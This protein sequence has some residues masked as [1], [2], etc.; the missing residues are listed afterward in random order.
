VK[1]VVLAAGFGTRLG[2]LTESSPK[3]ALRI[4]GQPIIAHILGNLARC[5]FE[6]VAVNVHYRSAEVRD[7]LESAP[8]LGLAVTWFPES[9]LLGTAGALLPMREFLADVDGFLVHYGDVLTDH[10]VGGMLG[11]HLV[12][13]PLVSMLVHER[14]ESNSIVVVD[15]DDDRVVRFLER[16]SPAEREGLDSRWVNS[17]IYAC[18]REVLELVPPPPSD[19]ARDLVPRAL[20]GGTVLVEEL[21]GYRCAVDSPARIAEA[22]LALADGRWRS[23]LV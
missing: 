6:E 19:I 2:P 15:D 12:R 20:A 1:A 23:A 7:A 16:P 5:G 3:A 9:E 14:H 4:G 13:R 22:E 18:S 8:D 10:D 21:S 17:G 11:R